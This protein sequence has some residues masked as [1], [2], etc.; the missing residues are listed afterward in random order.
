[1]AEKNEV[2]NRPKEGTEKKK[3]AWGVETKGDL[4]S[5][6]NWGSQVDACSL[7]RRKARRRHR[8]RGSEKGTLRGI[9]RWEKELKREWERKGRVPFPFSKTRGNRKKENL[10]TSGGKPK[11]RQRPEVKKIEKSRALNNLLFKWRGGEEK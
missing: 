6:K 9:G 7:I 10:T 2:F 5:G 1:V 11:G 8:S 3:G 4:A